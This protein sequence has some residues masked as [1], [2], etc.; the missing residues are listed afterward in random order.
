MGRWVMIGILALISVCCCCCT[1]SYLLH[2]KLLHPRMPL[3]AEL[4]VGGIIQLY[5]WGLLVTL[6]IAIYKVFK[7]A[8]GP[9][10]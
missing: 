9:R 6:G 1:C 2:A 3:N 10:Q 4:V 8:L 7:D 5:L